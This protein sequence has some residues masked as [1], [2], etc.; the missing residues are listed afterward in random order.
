MGRLL[1][2]AV[3]ALVIWSLYWAV[4]AFGLRKGVSGWF[5]AQADRG[6]QAEFADASTGGYPFSH[7][8][9]LRAPALAN[10][11]TG[12]AWQADWLRLESPAI[13]PGQQ[14]LLFPET[15][16]RFSYFDRTSTLDADDM[17]A[18]LHLKPGAALIVEKLTLT[19]EDWVLTSGSDDVI[20]AKDL[21]LSMVQQDQPETYRYDIRATSFSPSDSVRRTE[22]LPRVFEALE[23]RADVRF[24][25][26]WDRTAIEGNRPQP[27][28]IQ[29]D[30]AEAT[31]GE[32]SLKVAGALDVNDAGIPTGQLNIQAENWREMLML[33]ASTGAISQNALRPAERVLGM[34]AGLGGNPNTLDV[35]LGFKDGNVMLG[36]IPLGPAPRIVLR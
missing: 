1:K 4:A 29:L 18:E 31:W 36:P 25:R 13:W 28:H 34:L 33:A 2:I 20:G 15:T 35:K 23:M 5:A 27:R 16:Q 8:T 9:T 24:D 7:V 19:M 26:A 14:V 11:A 10:P 3:V 21:V 6:W 22:G 30:L 12:T 17:R 32:L